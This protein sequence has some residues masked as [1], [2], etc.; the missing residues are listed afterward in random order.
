MI[1]NIE[2]NIGDFDALYESLIEAHNG[3]SDAQSMRLNECLVSLL[4]EYIADPAVIAEAEQ[5]AS[6][7]DH[8]GTMRDAKLVLLMSNH[9]GD[10]K[11]LRDRFF[12]ARAVAT[13][14]EPQSERRVS[15]A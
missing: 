9:I 7:C 10:L 4:S 2:P 13:S 15:A 12:A 8:Q 3:L 14:H 5:Y 11:R 6:A 1:L